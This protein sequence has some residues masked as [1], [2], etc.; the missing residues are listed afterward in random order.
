MLTAA[1]NFE[2]VGSKI[3][4]EE[5][6]EWFELDD[7]QVAKFIELSTHLGINNLR[8]EHISQEKDR[9]VLRIVSSGSGNIRIDPAD[10]LPFTFC[11][12]H[13]QSKFKFWDNVPL[14]VPSWVTPSDN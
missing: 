8:T 12:R 5:L 3:I 11:D 10:L 4:G 7:D 14:G 1:T 9:F 2:A 6:N 13:N